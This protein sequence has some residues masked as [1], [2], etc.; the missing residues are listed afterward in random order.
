MY[1][2]GVECSETLDKD[3]MKQRIRIKS[4]ITHPKFKRPRD[5]NKIYDVCLLKVGLNQGILA[6]IITTLVKNA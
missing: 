4:F 5:E 3:E 1:E 2:V 6:M